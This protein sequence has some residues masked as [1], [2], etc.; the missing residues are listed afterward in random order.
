MEV[1]ILDAIASLTFELNDGGGGG[2]KTCCNGWKVL[3]CDRFS[4][5]RPVWVAHK[6]PDMTWI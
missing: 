6:T 1:V 4:D 5:D 2:K 3:L